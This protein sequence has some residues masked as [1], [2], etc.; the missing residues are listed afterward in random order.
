MAGT[1]GWLVL[2]VVLFL[3]SNQRIKQVLSDDNLITQEFVIVLDPGHAGE[4]SGKVSVNNTYEKDL[5]LQIA[6]KLK[7]YLES[8]DVKVVMTRD[9]DK[10]LCDTCSQ[11]KKAEDMRNRCS[12]INQAKPEFTVSIHQNSYT[13]GEISGAQV[14]YH[15]QSK[16]GKHIAECIQ[17]NLIVY[18]DKE[19]KRAA[20]GN[21]S[22]YILKNT[23]SPTVIVECGFLSNKE[24]ADKLETDAYQVRVAWAIH[25]SVM[26]L[27]S[28]QKKS[29]QQTQPVD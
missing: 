20:K 27:L 9:Q 19:N 5:N 3:F 11:H 18:L 6:A 8:S 7:K 23:E 29:T 1:L 28:S 10:M 16:Q 22:Y 2:G 21:D 13:S 25:M 12:I 4:D 24:E 15:N 17:K 14:F 26:E